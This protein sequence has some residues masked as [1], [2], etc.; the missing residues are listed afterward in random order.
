[1]SVNSTDPINQFVTLL[2]NPRVRAFFDNL[3]NTAVEK[4]IRESYETADFKNAVEQVLLTSE[5]KPIKRIAELETVTGRND[6][7]D[8]EEED[9]EPT[10]PEQISLLE[11]KIEAISEPMRAPIRETVNIPTSK[12][13]IRACALV[14]HLRDTGK[15]HLTTHEIIHFLKSKLP[16]S[17]KINDNIQNIRKVKQDVLNKATSMYPNV[18]LS[19]KKT[20]HREVRLVLSS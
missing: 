12:T 15:D 19:K 6:F 18:F 10:I 1:M 8:L 17:C 5:L 13:E 9:H 7:S 2:E 20:G 11:E 4:K 16:E 3:V 14:D